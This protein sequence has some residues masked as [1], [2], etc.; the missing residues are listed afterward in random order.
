MR[1]GIFFILF[2]SWTCA[3][4]DFSAMTVSMDS[5]YGYTDTNPLRMKK[6]N[7]GESIG[8][9][10]DFLTGLSTTDNQTL[11]FIRRHTV[12]NPL[13]ENSGTADADRDELDKYVFVTSKERD[14]VTI[15]VDVYRRGDLRIPVGLKYP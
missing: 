6:G 2:T 15:Y 9:S 3:P 8:Y 13:Y 5:T 4:R 12:D 7:F 14:T 1:I 11:K 10:Y